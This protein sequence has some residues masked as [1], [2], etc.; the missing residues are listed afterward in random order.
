M[1]E[2][3]DKPEQPVPKLTLFAQALSDHFDHG[4]SAPRCACL[5][6]PLLPAALLSNPAVPV[7]HSLLHLPRWPNVCYPGIP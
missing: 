4:I 7:L 1:Q 6:S 3:V 5:N 2:A